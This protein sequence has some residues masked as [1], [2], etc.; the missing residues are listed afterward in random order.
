MYELLRFLAVF[1]PTTSVLDVFITRYARRTEHLKQL[2]LIHDMCAEYSILFKINTVV[3][4][5]NW[6][7][8]LSEMIE[9]LN[10][11]RW[12]VYTKVYT[13]AFAIIA[14]RYL[15]LFYSSYHKD[16]VI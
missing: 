11:M 8:D 10:P 5:A 16:K 9:T 15:W 7:E 13:K 3:C 14:I 2:Q 12:K 4:T 6:E 1:L